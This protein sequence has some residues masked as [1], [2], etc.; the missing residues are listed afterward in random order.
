MSAC[1]HCRLPTERAVRRALATG[2]WRTGTR[3]TSTAMEPRT[4]VAK[5]EWHRDE[6]FPR[7]GFLVT[8]LRGGARPVIDFHNGFGRAQQA[9][10]EGKVAPN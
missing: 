7:G 9:M 10:K 3:S 2:A 1:T 5:V 8:N 6:L 4:V